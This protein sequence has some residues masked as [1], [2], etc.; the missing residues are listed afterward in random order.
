MT[1]KNM[2]TTRGAD[3]F[4]NNQTIC[5]AIFLKSTVLQIQN[6]SQRPSIWSGC[7]D[8]EARILEQKFRPSL[9]SRVARIYNGAYAFV[10]TANNFRSSTSQSSLLILAFYMQERPSLC[11][12][13][14]YYTASEHVTARQIDSRHDL[15]GLRQHC[16]LRTLFSRGGS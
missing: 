8:R 9:G 7:S 16:R 12:R 3:D 11:S 1:D 5:G 6:P 4:I 2:L 15:S 10:P 13:E 14:L